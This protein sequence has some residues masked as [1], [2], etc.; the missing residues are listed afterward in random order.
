MMLEVFADG[1][2]ELHGYAVHRKL[3]SRDIHVPLSRL[4]QVLHEM[5]D[6]GLL[7]DRWER[8][9]SGPKKRVYHLSRMGYSILENAHS[10]G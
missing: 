2:E 3:L 1:N 9:R 8:S 10:N 7:E 5:L 6:E 4:Y